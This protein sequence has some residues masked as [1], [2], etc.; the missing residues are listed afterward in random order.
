MARLTLTL[1]GGFEG[2]LDGGQPLVLSAR[3]AWALLAYLALR[4]GQAHP[5]DKLTALLWGGVAETRARASLRQALSTLRRALGDSAGLL[6]LESERAGLD[7]QALDVDA[8]RLEQ[9]LGSGSHAGLEAA[10]ALYRGDLLAGLAL[11]EP[12]F[13]E[14]LVAE[15]ERLRELV[16]EGLARLLARQRA[17]GD[18]EAGVDSALRL[19]AID[20]L[21]EPV[22]R[23][24]M[25][26]YA[27]LGRRGDALRQYREC[28]AVLGRELAVEPETE[29]RQV[30][31]EI[32]RERLGPPAPANR[33]PTV[34]DPLAAPRRDPTPAAPRLTEVSLVGR[35]VELDL[36]R[37]ALDTAWTG[38]PRLLLV[39]GEAGIGKS[40]LIAEGAA[41]AARRGGRVLVGQCH[42][43]DQ[44]LPF[45]P[46]VDLLRTPRAALG[47]ELGG[48]AAVSRAEL[49]RLLPELSE[50][51]APP[52]GPA[53]HRRLFEAVAAFAQML[54]RSRPLVL[55]LEDIHWADEPSLRLTVSL[56]RRLVDAPVLVVASVREE[57]LADTPE[58]ARGLDLVTEAGTTVTLGPLSR[59]D[60]ARLV[61]ALGRRGADAETTSRLAD[62]V[63]A[64]S[65]GHPLM[66]VEATRAFGGEAE[67]P[68]AET[69]VS[70]ARLALP[71]R[72]HDLVT[73]RLRRVS[74]AGRAVLAGAAVADR[75]VDFAVLQQAAGLGEAEAAAAV[76][77][78]V[79]RRLLREV[80]EGLVVGHDR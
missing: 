14:W 7:A 68:G 1:L 56:C 48:L 46:W 18:L 69:D 16:L 2:R 31:Q 73:R 63:W 43:S 30:Y 35:G 72:I 36:L 5:R 17:A 41:E 28:V 79:R 47:P 77:E 71:E 37:S 55:V 12:P 3:K 66:A 76:E 33:G 38:H 4:P 50:T 20:P 70:A 34:A 78:L 45:G 54:S 22:H 32:L 6:V 74:E 15:R 40:R 26:L 8:I 61:A 10:V 24:L 44:A 29:T 52:E 49:A 51:A 19:L 60:T 39:R 13:E 25:R 53:H 58:H 42:E 80:G 23:T 75:P 21:Q 57:D 64:V 67:A 59:P 11:D 27:G 9:A 65:E 62:R